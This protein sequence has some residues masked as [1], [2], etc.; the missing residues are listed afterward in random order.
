[1]DQNN[2][3][4][5]IRAVDAMFECDQPSLDPLTLTSE[6][7]QITLTLLPLE[8]ISTAA[9]A[10][11]VSEAA[12]VPAPPAKRARLPQPAVDHMRQWALNAKSPH[13]GQAERAKMAA[14]TGIT[15]D[16]VTNWFH[17]YRK[18]HWVRNDNEKT[19]KTC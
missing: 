17:N 7:C 12:A 13:P 4:E 15:A 10:S 6:Q 8:P 18:R 1:M 2:N 16:Q 9:S 5:M 11:P 3:D 19:E 14:E